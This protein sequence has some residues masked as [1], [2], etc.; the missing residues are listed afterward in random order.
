MQ[1]TFLTREGY[2]KIEQELKS[3][4][5]VQ[6]REVAQRLCETLPGGDVAENV[7]LEDARN[8]YAFLEGRIQDLKNILANA[9]IIEETGCT[10]TVEL[11][12]RVTVVDL[13]GDGAPEIY[14]IVGSPEA[15]PTQGN[16]SNESPLGR[17]LMGHRVGEDIALATPDGEVTFRI[18]GIR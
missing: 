11:G 3:L 17:A 16:I 12:N 1:Q 2:Y 4:N 10:D 14:R 18:V 6:R 13:A 8:A 15:D 7:E 5:T 9:V